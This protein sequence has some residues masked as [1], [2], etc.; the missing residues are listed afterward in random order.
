[1]ERTPVKSENKPKRAGDWQEYT[2]RLTNYNKEKRKVKRKSMAKGREQ[3]PISLRRTDESYTE[4]EERALLLLETHFPGRT[5]YIPDRSLVELGRAK[6]EDWR[7]AK[8]ICTPHRLKWAIDSFQPFK[9]NG[10]TAVHYQSS[11]I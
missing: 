2:E 11:Q 6:Q 4:D 1:V 9:S 3:G 10:T 7:V 5:P 8:N